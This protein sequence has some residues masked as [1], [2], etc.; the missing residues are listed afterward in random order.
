MGQ[1]NAFD[2]NQR[3]PYLHAD[4]GVPQRACCGQM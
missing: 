3:E 2:T 1:Q 4:Q